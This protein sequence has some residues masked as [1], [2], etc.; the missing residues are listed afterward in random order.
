MSTYHSVPTWEEVFPMSTSQAEF[1]LH[2]QKMLKEVGEQLVLG[3]EHQ[4]SHGLSSLTITYV[5]ILSGIFVEYA[6][7]GHANLLQVGGF[8]YHGI[9]EHTPNYS[10]LTIFSD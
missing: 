3:Q 2:N 10:K 8:L 5:D 7:F 4:R 6:I 9:S 1:D